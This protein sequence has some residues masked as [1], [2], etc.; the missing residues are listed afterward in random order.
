MTAVRRGAAPGRGWRLVRARPGR[1]GWA[2]RRRIRSGAAR[3]RL[4]PAL[5]TVAVLVAL[6][7]W[8]GW[9]SPFFA[10]REV[11]VSGVSVLTVAD[12]RE[13]VGVSEGTPLL[14]VSVSTVAA[15]VAEL[16]PVREVVVRRSWPDTLLVEVVERTAAAAVPTAGGYLLVDETGVPYHTVADPQGLPL[17]LVEQPGPGDRATLAGLA[18]LDSLTPALRAEL[19]AVRV[20]GPT[21]I[22]LDLRDGRVVVWGDESSGEEKARVATAL[23][24]RAVELIDVSTPEVVVVR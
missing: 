3:R 13:A 17:L 5:V 23:L 16:P 11:Q 1:T 2:L 4:V 19:A 24:E 14:R 18:V 15:R 7:A 22:R 8:V 9:A 21:E 6:A 20:D 10:V 12:V